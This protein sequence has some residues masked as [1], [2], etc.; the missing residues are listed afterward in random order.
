MKKF[1]VIATFIFTAIAAKAPTAIIAST[2]WEGGSL[3]Q[4]IFSMG[5]NCYSHTLTLDNTHARL[6]S[7]SVKVVLHPEDS[8]NN[9]SARAEMQVASGNSL[10]AGRDDIIY[11]FSIFYPSD[12]AFDAVPELFTQWLSSNDRSVNGGMW[13]VDDK[14]YLKQDFYADNITRTQHSHDFG[15]L[16]KGEWVDWVFRIKSSTTS[17]GHIQ[18]WRRRQFS[19]PGVTNTGG[20]ENLLDETGPNTS[21]GSSNQIYF[22]L[23][24]YKW[25]W[26]LSTIPGYTSDYFFPNERTY[27]IDNFKLGDASATITDFLVDFPTTPD[28]P[29]PRPT[30]AKLIGRIKGTVSN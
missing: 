2:S 5:Q 13:V 9:G 22:K 14:V 15:A 7:S 30:G 19:S 24:I 17:D 23:G 18:I 21:P 8:C 4:G 10:I 11:G 12:Y 25:L 29:T 6:G 16:I 1:I 27:W 26:H 3:G 28:I 20:F